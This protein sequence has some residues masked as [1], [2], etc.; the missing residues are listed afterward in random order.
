[1]ETEL[2]HSGLAL[3]EIRDY[4]SLSILGAMNEQ[5]SIKKTEVNFKD[6]ENPTDATISELL[7]EIDFNKK[8]VSTLKKISAIETIIS[9]HGWS[10]FDLSGIIP[11]SKDSY[12]TQCFIGTEEEYQEKFVQ[13]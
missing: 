12:F 7:S 1:M 13:Y 2:L 5:A 6:F 4:L 9:F 11:K 10:R 8:L 3:K